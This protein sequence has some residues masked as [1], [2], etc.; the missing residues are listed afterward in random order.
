MLLNN[1]NDLQQTPISDFESTTTT[2]YISHS[3]NCRSMFLL[4]LTCR[5]IFMSVN[6]LFHYNCGK[7]WEINRS[8]NTIFRSNKKLRHN[9]TGITQINMLSSQS[10]ISTNIF[11]MRVDIIKVC[12][13][14]LFN[15]GYCQ[16]ATRLHDLSP[17]FPAN[18]STI[19]FMYKWGVRSYSTKISTKIGG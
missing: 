6:K 17:I 12:S 3:Y 8:L 4:F 2:I 5:F 7:H 10:T 9:F 19:S 13:R 18:T 16:K 1:K 15:G 14:I 11:I